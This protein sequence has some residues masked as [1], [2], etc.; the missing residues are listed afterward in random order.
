MQYVVCLRCIDKH[1]N[2]AFAKT[3]DQ[4]GN[5]FDGNGHE[6]LQMTTRRIYELQRKAQCTNMDID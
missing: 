3:N 6:E 5:L 1:A 2:E 4:I